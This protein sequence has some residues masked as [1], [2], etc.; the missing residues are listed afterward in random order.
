LRVCFRG[1]KCAYTLHTVRANL[2]YR[3]L[4]SVCAVLSAHI[5]GILYLIYS[6]VLQDKPQAH[7][8]TP[9]NT[10]TRAH[11]HS[12]DAHTH[13]HTYTHIHTHSH[14]HTCHIASTPTQAQALATTFALDPPPPSRPL[15]LQVREQAV[16]VQRPAGMHRF[17]YSCV[18][19]H[20]FLIVSVSIVYISGSSLS[21]SSNGNTCTSYIYVCIHHLYVVLVNMV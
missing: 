21:P 13:T 6:R 18:C 14:A 7:K 1:S 9:T 8:R 17:I 15:Y 20:N 2:H 5:L 12:H 10:D 3:R 11:A 4:V 19:V 16:H